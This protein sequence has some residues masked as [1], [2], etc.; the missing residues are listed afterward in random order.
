MGKNQYI[1]VGTIWWCR[2]L[3]DYGHVH[4]N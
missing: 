1:T 3:R 4:V 2:C